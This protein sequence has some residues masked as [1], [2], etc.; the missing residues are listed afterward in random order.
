MKEQNNG[1]VVLNGTLRELPILNAWINSSSVYWVKTNSVRDKVFLKIGNSDK[2]GWTATSEGRYQPGWGMYRFYVPPKS[3]IKTCETVYRIITV[4]DKGNRHVEGE[5]KLRVAKPM[6]TDVNDEIRTVIVKFDDGK[7]REVYV[8]LDSSGT[9]T[10]VIMENTVACEYEPEVVYSHNKQS[11]LYHALMGKVGKEGVYLEL[12]EKGK[13]GED[14]SFVRDE[15]SG[16]YRR[17]ESVTDSAGVEV[18]DSGEIM[19]G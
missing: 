19:I 7:C 4:D 14:M 6:I 1:I 18:L 12:D 10:Y 11:G 15:D 5:G 9:P 8:E 3:F 13:T 2:S 16:F 17:V